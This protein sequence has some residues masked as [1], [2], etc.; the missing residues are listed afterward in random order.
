[1][2]SSPVDGSTVVSGAVVVFIDVVPIVV[3]S[4][5]ST[6]V[7]FGCGA[8]SN[9]LSVVRAT[10]NAMVFPVNASVV[11]ALISVVSFSYEPLDVVVS[12]ASA[13]M[14]SNSA[15]LSEVVLT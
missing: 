1:M 12:S 2:I 10:V 13:N 7:M 15:F 6:F 5:A 3:F 8:F 11:K 4:A 14:D 9:G